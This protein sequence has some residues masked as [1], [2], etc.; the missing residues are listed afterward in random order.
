MMNY[1]N[2]VEFMKA[3]LKQLLGEEYQIEATQITKNNGVKLDALTIR[4]AGD[5]VSPVIYME[6]LYKEYTNGSPIERL[7]QMVVARIKSECKFAGVLAEQIMSSEAAHSRIAFRLVS[8]KENEKLLEEIP[9]KSWNDLAIIFYLDLGTNEGRQIT[10]II[11]N[12]QAEAWNLSPDELFEL[13]KVNTP[14]LCPSII[15]QLEHVLFGWDEDDQITPCESIVPTFF[16]LSNECGINGATCILYKDIVKDFA[17]KLGSDL[18][19]LPSSIHEVLLL[20]Y[21]TELEL[22]LFKNMV[23]H[24]NAEDVPKEDILSDNVYLYRRDTDWIEVV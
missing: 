10:T 12:Q 7:A 8:K 13:A 9:W 15:G 18:L 16:I 23:Q 24:V 1:D 21:D 22:E 19:I 6:P 2:F 20:K 11:H 4:T 17:N 3:D 14:K 5:P